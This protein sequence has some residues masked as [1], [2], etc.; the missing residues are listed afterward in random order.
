MRLELGNLALYIGR[1]MD[2]I[3]GRDHIEQCRV[4]VPIVQIH[5]KIKHRSL[6]L[7]AY[8]PHDSLIQTKQQNQFSYYV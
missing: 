6:A 4:T 3:K 5:N 8:K 2:K 1:R 7:H